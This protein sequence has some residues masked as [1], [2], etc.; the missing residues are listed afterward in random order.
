MNVDRKPFF[1]KFTDEITERCDHRLSLRRHLWSTSD[2]E[3][4]W[5]FDAINVPY[6][7]AI[8]KG[9]EVAPVPLRGPKAREERVIEIVGP[10]PVC[11]I[12]L[13]IDHG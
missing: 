3:A 13:E 9:V 4:V 2:D 12:K 11:S 10:L 7:N 8:A 1:P 5:W 6:S